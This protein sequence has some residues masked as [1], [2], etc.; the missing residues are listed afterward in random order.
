MHE[1]R[2]KVIW[3]HSEKAAQ[4]RDLRKN[5]TCQ[6]LDFR[7]QTLELWEN[8]YVCFFFLKEIQSMVFCYGSFSTLCCCC[9]VVKLCLFATLWTPACQHSLSFTISL[10]LL[11]LFVHWVGDAIQPSHF[12]SS[13]SL[14]AFNLSHHQGLFQ[15][16]G[17][18]WKYWSFSL[19]T[20]PSN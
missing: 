7:L 2:E 5:Q 15:W 20:S 11:K 6:H 16:V 1:H 3:Q 8:T 12:L 9:S 19:G 4:V 17:S 14:S 13:P 10:S 18:L